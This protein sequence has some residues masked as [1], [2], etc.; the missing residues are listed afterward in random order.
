MRTHH[1][2]FLAKRTI[3]VTILRSFPFPDDHCH[4]DMLVLLCKQNSWVVQTEKLVLGDSLI[5]LS[6]TVVHSLRIG[7]YDILEGV[8]FQMNPSL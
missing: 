3:L 4:H 6:D 8:R 1:L 2:P 7:P 5:Q